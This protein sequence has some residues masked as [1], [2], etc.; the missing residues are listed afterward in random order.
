MAHRVEIVASAVVQDLSAAVE[1]QLK[2]RHQIVDTLTDQDEFG[3]LELLIPT[4]PVDS[5]F[6]LAP[7]FKFAEIGMAPMSLVIKTDRPILLIQPPD[8]F[9][10]PIRSLF[11]ATHEQSN[12][13]TIYKFVNLNTLPARV[14]LIFGS[15]T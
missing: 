3:E 8:T 14:K 13:P 10:Q 15:K 2:A 11:V 9:L 1:D 12:A 6:T 7:L 4:T 5:T